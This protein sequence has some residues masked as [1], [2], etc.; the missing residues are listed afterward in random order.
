[1]KLFKFFCHHPSLMS[2]AIPALYYSHHINFLAY[3]PVFGFELQVHTLTRCLTG[4]L[5]IL[6]QRLIL[7]PSWCIQVIQPV[8]VLQSNIK[9]LWYR[10]PIQVNFVDFNALSRY[11]A[12]FPNSIRDFYLLGIGGS[13]V[14]ATLTLGGMYLFNIFDF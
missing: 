6:F 5:K 9:P 12:Y 2:V 13:L 11:K 3:F 7:L 14:I 8:T 1:M 10:E 4:A